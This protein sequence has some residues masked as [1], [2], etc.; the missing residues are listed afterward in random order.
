MDLCSFSNLVLGSSWLYLS[1]LRRLVSAVSAG[2]C[3]RHDCGDD[4]GCTDEVGDGNNDVHTAGAAA[5][6]TVAS[7]LDDGFASG[8]SLSL[9]SE[10]RLDFLTE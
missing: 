8:L 2:H 1:S 10:R 6:G 3:T 9:F 4:V 5:G 7:G